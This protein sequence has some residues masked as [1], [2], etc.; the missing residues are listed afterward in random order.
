M[1]SV[2]ESVRACARGPILAV[3]LAGRREDE[4]HGRIADEQLLELGIGQLV[5]RGVALA[6]LLLGAVQQAAKRQDELAGELI[7]QRV[8]WLIDPSLQ[9]LVHRRVGALRQLMG[10]RLGRQDTPVEVGQRPPRS[11]VT[12]TGLDSHEIV[13][14]GLRLPGRPDHGHDLVLIRPAPGGLEVFP[15]ELLHGPD[16]GRLRLPVGIGLARETDP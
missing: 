7:P 1:R 16:L 6:A 13:G 8:A 2:C 15:V 12:C 4:V 3:V 5:E 14:C 10:H 11:G 9:G